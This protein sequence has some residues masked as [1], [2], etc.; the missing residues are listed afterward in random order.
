MGVVYWYGRR[1]IV[2]WRE[3]LTKRVQGDRAGKGGHAGGNVET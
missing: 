2:W 1:E 3:G